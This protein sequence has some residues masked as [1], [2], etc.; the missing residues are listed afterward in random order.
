MA[1]ITYENKENVNSS[2]LPDINKINDSD[3]NMIKNVVN[4]NAILNSLSEIGLSEL[5]TLDAI[6]TAVPKGKT[7]QVYLTTDNATVLYNST[8]G[9]GNIPA[10]IAGLL[11]VEKRSENGFAFIKYQTTESI[12]SPDNNPDGGVYYT[13]KL[14][15]YRDWVKVL[16]NSDV[17]DGT[18]ILTGRKIDGKDEYFI[19]KQI[20][21]PTANDNFSTIFTF[22][23]DIKVHEMSNMVFPSGFDDDQYPNVTMVE[24]IF[25]H[26][27]GV[28]ARVTSENSWWANRTGII[29]MYFTYND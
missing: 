8:G 12:G 21:T 26:G 20:T 7:L 2:A 18:P 22:T 11:T 15:V 5:T 3:M 19:E 23:Q 9:L 27:T 6:V 1:Q 10:T 28:I 25:R 16:C 17:Q 14:N 29:R 4:A 24:F 13:T